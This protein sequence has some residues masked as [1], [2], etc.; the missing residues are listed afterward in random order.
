[1]HVRRLH[2]GNYS[3]IS[4]EIRPADSCAIFPIRNELWGTGANSWTY[5]AYMIQSPM[6][7]SVTDLDLNAFFRDAAARGTIQN[8]WYLYAI[9]A[10]NELRTGAIPYSNN[11]CGERDTV[12]VYPKGIA[13]LCFGPAFAVMRGMRW[14]IAFLLAVSLFTGCVGPEQH[15]RG[16]HR[17]GFGGF[18]AILEGVALIADLAADA[19]A[20]QAAWDSQRRI[21]VVASP[22][23]PEPVRPLPAWF[24]GRVLFPSTRATLPEIRLAVRSAAGGFFVAIFDSDTLGRFSFAVPPAGTY[25]VVVLDP[26][27]QGEMTFASNGRTA[28]PLEFPISP[29]PPNDVPAPSGKS[30]PAQ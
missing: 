29:R 30:S 6:V 5:L 16:G 10:G 28:F 23:A 22:P 17:G 4:Y 20:T 25:T 14:R 13:R 8:S 12:T 15:V 2:H 1:M 26:D 19:S 9:Q 3:P 7:T 11:S 18:L 27:Y 21:E 24:Q